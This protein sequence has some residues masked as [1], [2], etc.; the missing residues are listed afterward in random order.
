MLDFFLY[1]LK[2]LRFKFYKILK[3]HRFAINFRC[4]DIFD[5]LCTLTW[6]RDA[7]I[8]ENFVGV[9][10]QGKLLRKEVEVARSKFRFPRIPSKRAAI[11]QVRQKSEDVRVQRLHR[12]RF[13][14]LPANMLNDI[15]LAR[16]ACYKNRLNRFEDVRNGTC[17][18]RNFLEIVNWKW[19]FSLV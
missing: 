15:K 19:N 18:L 16:A 6:V 3:C 8:Y 4:P 7:R 9:A 5:R 1:D 10:A 2:V 17:H 12:G 14:R 13:P 11:N